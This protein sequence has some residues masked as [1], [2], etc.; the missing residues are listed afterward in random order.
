MP[1]RVTRKLLRW[2]LPALALAFAAPAFPQAAGPTIPA[3]TAPA[4]IAINP[5]TNKLY[6]ANEGS[7]D[8]TVIDG[9][10]HATATIPVATRP[11]WIAVN[12]ETN[13]VYVS[14]FGVPNF[15]VIDGATNAVGAP[16]NMGDVGW[17]AINP[18]TNT[19]F[20]LRYGG[21]DEV[22]VIQNDV[23]QHTSATRSYQPVS[24]VVNPVTNVLYIAHQATGDVAAFDAAT[25]LPGGFPGG[26]P[27]YP[28]RLC[29]NG[30]GGYRPSPGQFDPD[31]GACIDIP[32]PIIA[33]TVNPVTNMVYA[34]SSSTSGQIT[35]IRGH[36]LSDPHTFQSFTPPGVTGAA[37]AIA[38]NPVT[39]KVYAAFASHVVIFDGATNAMT[40][41][42][43]GAVAIGVNPS[44]NMI[45]APN[46]S[47]TLN[48]ISGS[49]NAV[50]ATLAIPSGAKAIA[51]NPVTNKVFVLTSSGV[52]PIQGS[53][54]DVAQ[55]IALTTT[56]TP[57]AGNSSGSSGSIT[58]SASAS[59]GMP[60][61]RRVYYE[62][63]GTT[64]AWTAASG[65]GTGPYTASFSGLA[66]GSHTL[67]AFATNALDAPS[68]VTD[69]QNNPLIGVIASYTFTVGSAP[70]PRV[71]PMPSLATSQSPSTAGTAVTFTASLTGNAGTPTGTAAFKDGGSVI[72]GCGAVALSGG[73]ATCTTSALTA[74]THN[75]TADYSGDSAYNAATAGPISQVVNAPK[76]TP[77]VGLASS[78][79]PATAGQSVTLTAT[80]SGGA[81]TATGTIDFRNG[82]TSIAGCAAVALS[83]GSASCSTTFAAGTY[84][85][86]A[87]YGGNA[88]YNGATSP[89]VTQTVNAPPPS[90]TNV[91]LAS[92]GTV[93]TASSS[94]N[95]GFGPAAV[96]NGDRAGLNWSAG[97]GW[98]D[99]TF[100]A[101]PDWVQLTFPGARTIDRVIVYSLQDDPANPSEPT[102]AMTF[103]RYGLVDFEVQGWNGAAWQTLATV[104][105]NNLVKRSVSFAAFTTTQVRVLVTQALGGYSHVTE[106]E[107]FGQAA[108]GTPV[109]SNVAAASAG[110]TASASSTYS[111]AFPASAAIDGDRAG[112]NWGAGSGWNDATLGAYPDWLQVNFAGARTIDRVVVYTLQDDPASPSEPTDSMTFSSYGII[113]FAVQ[114]WDGSAWVTLA[115]VTGNNLVKRTVTFAPYTTTQLRVLVT[116]A[117]GYSHIVEVEAWGFAPEGAGSA[118]TN[119]ALA[120]NGGMASAS[121]T[122]SSAFPAS[123]TIDGDRAGMNWGAGSG[124]NDATPG[125][126]PD[127][128]QVDFSG[129]K[130]IDRVVVYTL[131]DNPS[132]PR[133]PTDS[134]TFTNYGIVDF[135]VEAWNGSAW[136]AVGS[137]RGNNLVKRTVTFSPVATSRI[138]ILVLDARG[139]SHITEVEAWSN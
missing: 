49:T 54:S 86:T 53:A 32:D 42:P 76:A 88:A 96:N 15:M 30:S 55:G 6:V 1:S 59:A 118:G 99:A 97:S 17:M 87:V 24:I 47:G 98:N 134:M 136:V 102:D 75:I 57:L 103:T 70:P 93:A 40:V 81:G 82:S 65:S 89:M 20:N 21:G 74:G 129:T 85:L 50:V 52:V 117:R 73:T 25:M 107:V 78:A 77:L 3:G 100:G 37:R 43:T 33:L 9:S 124:W 137:V 16:Q 120:A 2:A 132:A 22:N 46:E 68:V 112:R 10:S 56:I 80:V 19:V 105:G 12:P 83:A 60:A 135:D 138:R 13:K 116:N 126:Y 111:N 62:I 127:W 31:D 48:V 92:T 18:V 58:M 95:A 91:A 90:G 41:I 131:Q 39:N 44:T 23:Y 106:L 69:L 115:S 66:A 35:A 27:L 67:R 26:N 101:F 71:D 113:D 123:A 139:Y 28:K 110:A 133:E 5:V 51:V 79:N 36:G 125:E 84:N 7:N 8:V 119:V 34:V 45:Y 94:Y 104:S 29:P 114:G 63:D 4:A 11:L 130:T 128:L 109:S 121:S 122:Y 61:P 14:N 38:A 64:G 72:A 108:A